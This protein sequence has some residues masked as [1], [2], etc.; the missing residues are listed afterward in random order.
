MVVEPVADFRAGVGGQVVGDDP[1]RAAGVGVDDLGEQ[2][3]PAVAVAGRGAAG[4]LGAVADAQGAEDLG[5][6]GAAGV[7][8]GCFDAVAVG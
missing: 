1:D 3:Y 7:C 4:D 2:P 5:L 6:L 8:H